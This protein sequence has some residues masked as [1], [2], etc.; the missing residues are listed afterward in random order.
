M[1]VGRVPRDVP[2]LQHVVHTNTAACTPHRHPCRHAE[3]MT[4]LSIFAAAESFAV[5]YITGVRS[6]TWR[7]M[8]P[9]PKR[10]QLK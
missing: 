4:Y 2:T 9:F 3:V 10:L 1:C 7:G 6:R 8:N 5:I